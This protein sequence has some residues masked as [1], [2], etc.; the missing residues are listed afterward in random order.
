[1]F[2]LGNREVLSGSPAYVQ[3]RAQLVAAEKV[4]YSVD[5]SPTTKWTI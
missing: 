3:C 4:T 1:M 2:R 5:P